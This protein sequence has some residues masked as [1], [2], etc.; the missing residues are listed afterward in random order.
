MNI[1]FKYTI[2][3]FT[4]LFSSCSKDDENTQPSSNTSILDI[5]GCTDST[6]YNFNSLAN[7]DDGTCIPFLFG[8]TDS[9]ASNFNSL[10]NTDDGSCL[11]AFYD[12]CQGVWNINPD[13]DE[14]TIPVI[15]TVIS[16]NDQLPEDIDVQGDGGGSIYIILNDN[17]LNG[18]I[19]IEGN[20]NVPKQ[21]VP[22]DMGFGPM[23]IDV[24]GAGYI[25]SEISGYMELIYSFEIDMIPG[26]PISESLTCS[27]ELYR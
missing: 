11:P 15:G 21:T 8:C 16:L 6:M 13:C 9:S 27:I 17:Q 26:F 1:T 5:Y 7:I 2:L 22:I 18:N 19:D 20:I 12:I 24:E 3:V 23:D 25:S 10:A 4:I 14:Y